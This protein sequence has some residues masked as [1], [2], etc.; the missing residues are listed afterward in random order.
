MNPLE[1]ELTLR[2]VYLLHASRERVYRAM[3]Q[4]EELDRWWGPAGFRTTTESI[5][6]RPGGR[7]KFRFRSPD[8]SVYHNQ[9]IFEELHPPTRL[10]YRQVWGDGPD[11]TE[12]LTT[13]ELA[14]RGPNTEVTMTFAFATPEIRRFVVEEARADRGNRETLNRLET[15]LHSL[16]HPM[17]FRVDPALP[18]FRTVRL[19]RAPVRRVWDAMTVAEQVGRWWGGAGEPGKT[20]V[21]RLDLRVG[22]EWAFTERTGPGEE[23]PFRGTFRE[24][25]PVSKLVYT[26][27]LDT[28]EWRANATVVTVLLEE[29]EGGTRL[30][31]ISSF[32]DRE[33]RKAWIDAGA[34]AGGGTGYDRLA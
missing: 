15:H 28:D 3:T 9:V 24:I 17:T 11:R 31:T 23:A 16:A 34:E 1:P 27:Y 30:T 14:T 5:D 10:V 26:M 6:L 20:E 22:G 7:W 13:V 8:G 19:F 29:H 12:F 32:P 21:R 33:A 2:S 18:E 25:T 4:P